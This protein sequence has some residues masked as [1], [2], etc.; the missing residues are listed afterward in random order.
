MMCEIKIGITGCF[1]TILLAL[2][3]QERVNSMP[4]GAEGNESKK[5]KDFKLVSTLTALWLPCVVGKPG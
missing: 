3:V 5:E 4:E 2:N 1:T